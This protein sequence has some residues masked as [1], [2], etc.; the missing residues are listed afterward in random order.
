M[1]A[2]LGL[3]NTLPPR[4]LG[5]V[6]AWLWLGLTGLLL[7][8]LSIFPNLVPAPW[9][10]VLVLI[11]WLV[12]PVRGFVNKSA[13][14]SPTEVQKR[15]SSGGALYMIIMVCFGVGFTF[16]ARHL[17][18][19]WKV[20]IAVLFLIEALPSAIVSLT[21]WWRLSTVGLAI[22]L[23]ICGFG[24]PLVAEKRTFVLLGG[25]VFFGS[26]LSGGILYWQLC[27][28]DRLLRGQNTP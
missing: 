20:V 21:E 16:W 18:L 6:W 4:S 15:V 1:N 19:T 3:P 22:G 27:R 10:S 24:F 25:A 12:L 28:E 9:G 17:G 13:P 26:L 8:A 5:D 11:C 2:T 14:K 23:M 7:V